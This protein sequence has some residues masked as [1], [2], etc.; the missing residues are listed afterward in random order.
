MIL[1]LLNVRE[2]GR[3]DFWKDLLLLALSLITT[4]GGIIFSGNILFDSSI[5]VL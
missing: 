2:L 4:G 3:L 1:D 5:V